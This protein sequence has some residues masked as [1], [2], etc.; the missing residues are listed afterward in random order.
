MGEGR[1]GERSTGEES[2][3]EDCVWK[4]GFGRFIY[5]GSE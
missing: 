2:V 1:K 4:K 3:R 5:D